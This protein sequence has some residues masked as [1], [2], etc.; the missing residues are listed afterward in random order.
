M[1]SYK[2]RSS[3]LQLV[4]ISIFVVYLLIVLKPTNLTKKLRSLRPSIN[5]D[6][7]L[8]ICLKTGMETS[9]ERV[10]VQLMTF[11]NNENPL[12]ISDYDELIGDHK[13][14]NILPSTHQRKTYPKNRHV[15]SVA[16]DEQKPNENN[17]GWKLDAFKNYPGFKKLQIDYPSS[18]WFIM[19]DDDTYLFKNNLINHLKTLSPHEAYYLGAANH[20]RGCDGVK[21][22]GDGPLFAHGGSGIVINRVALDKLV[23]LEESC[24]NKYGKCWAG[25]IRVALCLRDAG[26]LL[27]RM[28]SR[29]DFHGSPVQ[30]V[31]FSSPCDKPFTFHHLFP[32][33]IQ[34]LHELES[35]IQKNDGYGAEVNMG[36][37][38]NWVVKKDP[39][40]R[41]SD[42]L[43]TF[44]TIKNSEGIERQFLIRKNL[45]LTG[46]DYENFV[47]TLDECILKCFEDQSCFSWT[48]TKS[49]NNCW[50]KN[51]IP[52]SK[53]VDTSVSGWFEE[54]FKCTNY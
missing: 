17:E 54:K 29:N 31:K 14:F 33:Q 36:Q 18:K 46:S 49:N 26:I 6:D 1:A 5:S 3:N 45:D 15:D 9:L 40:L 37:I 42:E 12:I 25:D 11:L 20:F 38:F 2:L 19:I 21:R 8:A 34:L 28:A 47:S 30:K 22:L 35:E 50:K 16:K 44:K 39:M 51:G 13:V 27:D 23:P 52:T 43:E 32:F 53:K 4:S 10:P 7:Y 48:F 41:Q 24:T